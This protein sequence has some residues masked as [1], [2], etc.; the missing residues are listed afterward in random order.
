MPTST[1][2]HQQKLVYF[3]VLLYKGN[4]S[5]GTRGKKKPLNHLLYIE[6]NGAIFSV[7]RKATPRIANEKIQNIYP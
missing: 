7:R 6:R 1:M 2:T 4:T 3:F 5:E